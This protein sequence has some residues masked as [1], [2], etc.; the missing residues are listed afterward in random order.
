MELIETVELA[1]SASSITFSSIP[2][3]Y[4]D[5]LILGSSRTDGS[6]NE[7]EVSF[8]S[9]TATGVRIVGRSDNNSVSSSSNGQII[10]SRSV[11]TSNTFGSFSLYISNYQSS[12]N[13]SYSADGV[14]ENNASLTF[15]TLTAG[16]VSV[17]SA[18]TTV[19]LDAIGLNFVAGSIFSLYGI[20]AGGDGTVTTS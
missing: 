9:T 11:E 5:L 16:L 8:N 20:T 17:T 10:T 7:I 12:T 2:Q 4:T 18:V 3:T 15:Q 13:K 14:A 1:S 19:N 6:N